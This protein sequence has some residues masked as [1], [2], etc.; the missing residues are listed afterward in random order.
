MMN[1]HSIWFAL[2]LA[3]KEMQRAREKYRDVTPVKQNMLKY[4]ED[5]EWEEI[6]EQPLKL[7]KYERTEKMVE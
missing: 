4:A 1:R 7:E 3:L 5:V 2:H 6:V